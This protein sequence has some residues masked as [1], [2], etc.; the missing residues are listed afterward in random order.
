MFQAGSIR[1]VVVCIFTFFAACSGSGEP[2][3]SD[4]RAAFQGS[5][6]QVNQQ[7]VAMAGQEAADKTRAELHEL[8]KI[9]CHPVEDSAAFDCEVQ[10]E[11]TT[12]LGKQ[13]SATTVRVVHSDNGWLML[14]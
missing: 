13:S 14:Q 6:D 1:I 10:V 12:M 9:A 4:V 5:M 2:S 7:V 3:E 8:K 11:M